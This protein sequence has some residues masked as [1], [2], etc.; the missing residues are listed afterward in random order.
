MESYSVL[1]FQDTIYGKDIFLLSKNSDS[2]LQLRLT[3]IIIKLHT[4]LNGSQRCNGGGVPDNVDVTFK[5]H[6]L[7]TEWGMRA[8]G[9]I[10]E[11]EDSSMKR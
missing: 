2:T 3:S 9:T 1:L 8:L 6:G 7:D 5:W 10:F 11:V 4:L